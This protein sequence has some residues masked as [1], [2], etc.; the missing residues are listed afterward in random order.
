[1][2]QRVAEFVDQSL[3]GLC[4]PDGDLVVREVAVAV[5]GPRRF[6]RSMVATL[7]PRSVS[8]VSLYRKPTIQVGC[9][10]GSRASDLWK[11]CVGRQGLEP[12][13]PD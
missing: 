10:N 11:G 5:L 9:D 12:C 6:T 13:P 1:V 2:Q 7:E 8:S 4:R 3:D